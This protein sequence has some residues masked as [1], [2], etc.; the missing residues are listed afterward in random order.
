MKIHYVDVNT[1]NNAAKLVTSGEVKIN[2]TRTSALAY[3]QKVN[4]V[5]TITDIFVEID[6]ADISFIAQ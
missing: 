6:G 3:V 4:G 2:S 1:A 5:D